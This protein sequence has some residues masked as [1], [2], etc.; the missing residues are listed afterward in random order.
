[1]NTKIEKM[2]VTQF[3]KLVGQGDVY[4]GRKLLSDNYVYV[5]DYNGFKVPFKKVEGCVFLV[6]EDCTQIKKCFSNVATAVEYVMTQC[7][8]WAGLQ[9]PRVTFGVNPRGES[10]VTCGHFD[11]YKIETIDLV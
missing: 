8:G 2:T 11:S 7:K 4:K 3:A 5:V 6:K 9:K 10:Y 1:M